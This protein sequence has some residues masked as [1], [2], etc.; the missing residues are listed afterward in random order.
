MIRHGN[1]FYYHIHL[2]ILRIYTCRFSPKWRTTGWITIWSWRLWRRIFLLLQFLFLVDTNF[3]I[4]WR[5][6]WWLICVWFINFI[7]VWWPIFLLVVKYVL[8]ANLINNRHVRVI[9]QLRWYFPQGFIQISWQWPLDLIRRYLGFKV[10]RNNTLDSEYHT[11]CSLCVP[12]PCPYYK[13]CVFYVNYDF[14]KRPLIR[15]FLGC[16]WFGCPMHKVIIIPIVVFCYDFSII[17]FLN[18]LCHSCHYPSQYLLLWLFN[19]ERVDAFFGGCLY[20]NLVILS[21]ENFPVLTQEILLKVCLVFCRNTRF[22]GAFEK[23]F[24]WCTLTR[25]PLEQSH[26]FEG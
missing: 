7:I 14:T 3:S 26:T 20:R 10:S 21:L 5:L 24:E 8:S 15:F 1:L 13:V 19:V 23:F 11:I 17:L 2:C 25:N 12:V 18:C 22:P 4:W 9:Q 6:I 16:L